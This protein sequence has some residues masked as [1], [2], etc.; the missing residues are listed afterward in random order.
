M[1]LLDEIGLAED[2]PDMPLKALHPLLE[3]GCV[4]DENPEPYKKVGF[5]GISNWALDPAKMNRGLLVFRTEP[6]KEELV[7]TA[8]GICA[9]QPH[10]E[11]I[12]HL[13]PILANFYCNVLKT[14]ETEFFGLRDFYSL[15]KMIVSY[16]QNTKR[17]SQ[18]E[19]LVKAIQRNFGG[20]RD[21]HP[22][23]IFRNCTS[24]VRLTKK[25]ETSC[26][27]LLEENIHK[28]QVGFMSRY[29]LLLTTN[30]AAFQIIQMTR[31]IDVSN[32]DIIFGSGFPRD[33]DYSQ[34][35]RSVNRV[36]ICMEIGR[37]VVLLNIQNLYESLYDAL[38]QCFV[39]LGDNYYVDLGLGTHR[40]KS[41][42]K[43]E[44][45]LIVIEEEKVVYTQFPPPLLS[46]LEKH[47][48]DMNTI[49]NWGQQNLKQDLE[50]WAEQFVY[51]ENPDSFSTWSHTLA[52]KEHDVFIGFSDDNVCR[53]RAGE[54]P[55][56]QL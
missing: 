27:R 36:K 55:E 1:V 22:L 51:M 32:C 4:D 39:S 6:S 15:I 50:K 33:Q 54:L 12:E 29:L 47:C 35:C 42:V 11:R 34:V 21:I 26:I 5:V 46:R 10:L 37:P 31:L 7:N 18:E 24:E 44:F 41:R 48:L 13:F 45:R 14:Q 2:S 49:L 40:V 38:N 9:D 28:R 17:S 53:H 8:K 19:L 3:D 43:E 20:S 23:E 25:M 30:N 56:H 52:P 16:T